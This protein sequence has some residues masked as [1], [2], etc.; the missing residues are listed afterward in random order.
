[1][2]RT[3]RSM[4]PTRAPLAARRNPFGDGM[5]AITLRADRGWRPMRSVLSVRDNQGN[6]TRVARAFSVNAP[7]AGLF[8]DGFE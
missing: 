3:A 7:A 8:Q 6:I 5:F 2:L 4:A 1:M